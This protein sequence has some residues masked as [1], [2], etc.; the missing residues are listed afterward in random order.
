MNFYSMPVT[1]A[2]GQTA[3]W[4]FPVLAWIT[5]L[6]L[7]LLS[8]QIAVLMLKILFYPLKKRDKETAKK[9]VDALKK[10]FGLLFSALFIFIAAKLTPLGE[11]YRTIVDRILL[12]FI[13]ATVFAVLYTAARRL[14]V[15]L[16]RA[17][18][19]DER[20]QKFIQSGVAGYL[21]SALSLLILLV[22]ILAVVSVWVHNIAGVLAGLGI[23]GLAVALAAQDTLAN[24]IGSLALMLDPPFSVG[25]FIETSEL[26][27]TVI[28]IG[29]RSSMLRRMDNSI[30][31]VPNKTL[32]S[33][34]IMNLSQRQTR[35]VEREISISHENSTEQIEA[36]CADICGLIRKTKNTKPDGIL[37]QI[38]R[39]EERA[40]IL[41]VRYFTVQNYDLM[42]KATGEIMGGVM[43]IAEERK[44][45]LTRQ[46][47]VLP[48]EGLTEN[49]KE[50]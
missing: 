22:G 25:D 3:S 9:S 10:P 19:H 37:C 40:I 2:E 42:L 7:T 27:G 35:R 34:V 6:V 36:F 30:I 44:I 4:L 8:R 11:P 12:S 49:N 20:R 28:Q 31:H 47:P 14:P 18:R 29:L 46:F 1:M 26:D 50:I 41:L 45:Q 24:F 43:K 23:G 32:S 16:E 39:F 17:G 33:A 38:D 13:I 48:V 21:G 15:F 5:A